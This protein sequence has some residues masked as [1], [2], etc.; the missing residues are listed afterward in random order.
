MRLRPEQIAGVRAKVL[1]NTR[2]RAF[3]HEEER[4]EFVAVCMIGYTERVP[5]RFGDNAGAWPVRIATTV[6]PKAVATRPDLESP[7]WEIKVLEL[8]W[9]ESDAHAKRLKARLDTLLL[10]T[11]QD[12]REL[13]HGWRDLPAEP[14]VVWPVILEEALADIRRREQIVVYSEEQRLE[15]V[16]ARMRRGLR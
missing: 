12:C 2:S 8:V 6:K 16:S 5:R 13:R 11:S 3:R 10:G 14:A 15:R 1:A 4:L 7:L 9:C